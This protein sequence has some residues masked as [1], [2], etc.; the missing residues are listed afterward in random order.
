MHQWGVLIHRCQHSWVNCSSRERKVDFPLFRKTQ[1]SSF[2]CC[3][4]FFVSAAQLDGG[5]SYTI[6]LRF[7]PSQSAGSVEIL[8]YVNNLEE[9]TEETFCVKVNYSWIRGCRMRAFVFLQK[10]LILYSLYEPFV[11]YCV[12]V[13]LGLLVAV[14]M[15]KSRLYFCAI[16]TSLPEINQTLTN[17]TS[18]S[19]TVTLFVPGLAFFPSFE[20]SGQCYVTVHARLSGRGTEGESNNILWT[21]ITQQTLFNAT[22]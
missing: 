17:T 20:V 10:Y 19:S 18:S 7:A 3:C 12:F 22:L 15:N 13:R 6:G 4:F 2:R 9:K 5:E 1:I 8:V 14:W 16:L 21:L 11:F